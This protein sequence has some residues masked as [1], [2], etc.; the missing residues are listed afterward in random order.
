LETEASRFQHNNF[1]PKPDGSTK[2]KLSDDEI[3]AAKQLS[4]IVS[5]LSV[6]KKMRCATSERLKD[7]LKMFAN[8]DRQTKKV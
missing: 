1:V 3:E 6:K 4:D 7:V 8:E 5:N 2:L